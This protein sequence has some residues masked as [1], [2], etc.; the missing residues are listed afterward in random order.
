MSAGTNLTADSLGSHYQ[1][2]IVIRDASL[3][4]HGA[5]VLQHL[6]RALRCLRLFGCWNMPRPRLVQANFFG[7]LVGLAHHFHPT[8]NRV[9]LGTALGYVLGNRHGDLNRLS[10]LGPLSCVG[11]Q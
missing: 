11:I 1:Q 2:W 4:Q 10:N 5:R 9:A 3:M 6:N 7:D 8:L